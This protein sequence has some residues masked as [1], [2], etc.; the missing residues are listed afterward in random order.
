MLLQG[1]DTENIIIKFLI[2]KRRQIPQ[3]H[4]ETVCKMEKGSQ[5]CR[6]ISLTEIGYVCAKKTPMKPILD[7]LVIQEQLGSKGD[8]CDG[9]GK[10]IEDD[11]VKVNDNQK[12]G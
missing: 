6:Y 9:M 8:N 11:G 5:T 7:K 12:E 2:D 3:A 10:Q 1:I 4:L